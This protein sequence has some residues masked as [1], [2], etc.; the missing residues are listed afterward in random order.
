MTDKSNK[1]WGSSVKAM[2]VV[3]I[4]LLCAVTPMVSMTERGDSV[5][6]DDGDMP[7]DPTDRYY[8]SLGDS[9]TN[10]YGMFEYFDD[11]FTGKYTPD[12][13]FSKYPGSSE[14]SMGLNVAAPDAYPS[15]VLE[16]LNKNDYRNADWE[17]IQLATSGMRMDELRYLLDDDFYALYP[18][19]ADEYMPN[20]QLIDAME[21][22]ARDK[23]QNGHVESSDGRFCQTCMDEFREYY[24]GEIAKA[25][26]ITLNLGNNNFGTFMTGAIGNFMAGKTD[27]NEFTFSTYLNDD[28]YVD[29]LFASLF[30]AFLYEIVMGQSDDQS[31]TSAILKAREAMDR[32]EAEPE[33]VKSEL[34]AIFDAALEQ[35]NGDVIGAVLYVIDTAANDLSVWA[36]EYE[37]KAAELS[38]YLGN[39]EEFKTLASF[40]DLLEYVTSAM[41]YGVV[42]YTMNYDASMGWILDACEDDVEI[43]VVGVDNIADGL[44][45]ALDNMG[46]YEI[47]LGEI[48]GSVID[49]ANLYMEYMSPYTLDNRVSYIE[50]PNVHTYFDQFGDGTEMSAELWYHILR[51]FGMYYHDGCGAGCTDHLQTIVETILGLVQRS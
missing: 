4:M 8:V 37:A 15:L 19:G 33:A 1:T 14:Y 2:V 11:G 20:G 9:V 16:Q 35:Q 51:D 23:S 34:A 46:G 49:M 30:D 47:P 42:G 24:K 32:Y 36:E 38:L 45:L 13:L 27:F 31:I 50:P 28:G 29:E 7:V 12:Q 18:T 5:Y 3:A 25:S 22:W 44:V 40:I 17:L 10:G 41:F 21:S 39:V 43:V 6:A 26:L 48:Y